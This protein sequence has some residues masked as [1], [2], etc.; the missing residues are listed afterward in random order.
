MPNPEQTESRE[1]EKVTTYPLFSH[2]D[3][4]NASY[5][6]PK[7]NRQLISGDLI[8]RATRVTSIR[9]AYDDSYVER[10]WEAPHLWKP[11]DANHCVSFVL[12]ISTTLSSGCPFSFFFILQKKKKKKR[13]G[14]E[15]LFLS[16]LRYRGLALFSDNFISALRHGLSTERN[17]KYPNVVL[18]FFFIVS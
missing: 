15:L 16:V 8:A 6:S 1:L 13:R 2:T 10:D 12:R 3:I 11:A 14:T 9:H 7:M 4:P 17:Y 5:N 18:N